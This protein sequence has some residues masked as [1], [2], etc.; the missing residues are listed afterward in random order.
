MAEPA[1]R[2]A[3]KEPRNRFPDDQRLREAGFVIWSR[4]AK[5]ESIWIRDGV[6]YTWSEA[7]ADIR[8]KEKA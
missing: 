8:A 2:Y 3:T 6:R 1:Q 5:G 4:P 7:L